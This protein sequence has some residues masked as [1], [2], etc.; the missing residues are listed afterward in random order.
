MIQTDVGIRFL[1]E[2]LDKQELFELHVRIGKRHAPGQP[3]GLAIQGLSGHRIAAVGLFPDRQGVGPSAKA[4]HVFSPLPF[5]ERGGGELGREAVGAVEGLLYRGDEKRAAATQR[6]L[7]LSDRH[8]DRSR[9]FVRDLEFH[10]HHGR[11]FDAL[12]HD[13]LA[14]RSARRDDDRLHGQCQRRR[15]PARRA[16]FKRKSVLAES[17][18]RLGR[19]NDLPAASAGQRRRAAVERSHVGWKTG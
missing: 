9:S 16:K 17:E 5:R 13:D 3:A 19:P 2:T 18:F 15:Q 8:D 1:R 10:R 4:G 6:S 14:L 12:L 11:P 7:A